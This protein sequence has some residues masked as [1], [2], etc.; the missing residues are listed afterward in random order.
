MSMACMYCSRVQNCVYL[1]ILHQS[2]DSS[3]KWLFQTA[4]K[5]FFMFR[6][7][8]PLSQWVSKTND[9]CALWIIQKIQCRELIL[10][11]KSFYSEVSMSKFAFR[12]SA[13][14]NGGFEVSVWGLEKVHASANPVSVFPLLA[15]PVFLQKFCEVYPAE[16]RLGSVDILCWKNLFLKLGFVSLC[17][18]EW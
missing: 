4:S 2:W 3:R 1:Q 9:R 5:N 8:A 6:G 15:Q 10:L 13:K 11:W 16:S 12:A 18:M 17:L 14:A 7:P